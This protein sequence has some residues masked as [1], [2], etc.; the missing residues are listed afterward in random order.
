YGDGGRVVLGVE[1]PRRRR[2]VVGRRDGE[3]QLYRVVAQVREHHGQRPVVPERGVGRHV[4]GVG[5]GRYELVAEAA[6]EPVDVVAG[7]RARLGE[8]A[9]R[10]AGVGAHQV[11]VADRVRAVDDQLAEDVGPPHGAHARVVRGLPVRGR[12]PVRVRLGDGEPQVVPARGG[13]G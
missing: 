5:G 9:P 2:Q 12:A 10:A 6:V 13:D 4:L 11:E 8:Q 7:A 3:G 1:Q